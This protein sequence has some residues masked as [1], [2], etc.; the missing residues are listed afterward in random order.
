MTLFPVFAGKRQQGDV[1]GLFDGAR[2]G[3]LMFGTIASL[4]AW[5][6][7]AVVGDEALE[8]FY[9]LIV[10]DLLFVRAELAEL[11]ARE[12]A[13]STTR[14]TAKI[15]FFSHLL[16]QFTSLTLPRYCADLE[17]EFVF[18]GHRL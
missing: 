8:K 11:R 4:T 12:E 18:I 7:L 9:V 16:L 15:S 10:N 13:A 3:A 14:P 1:T 2:H 17:G 6:N 5:S